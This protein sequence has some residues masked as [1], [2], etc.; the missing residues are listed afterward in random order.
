[1]Q[2]LPLVYASLLFIIADYSLDGYRY[3]MVVRTAGY[4]SL[5]AMVVRTAG[6]LSLLAMA[7]SLY[8][9]LTIAIGVDM[10]TGTKVALIWVCCSYI[11]AL[12]SVAKLHFYKM[13]N[14]GLDNEHVRLMLTFYLSNIKKA[15]KTSMFATVVACLVI[16][17]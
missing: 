5:L 8:F 16:L 9:G 11:H 1:M 13:Q 4:L 6:Y 12:A 7:V 14:K 10:P 15:M 3:L 2:Y 17:A